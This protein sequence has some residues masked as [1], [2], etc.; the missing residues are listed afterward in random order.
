MKLQKIFGVIVLSVLTAIIGSVTPAS[1]IP[2]FA[3]KYNVTCTTCHSDFPK[4]NDFGVRF[5]QEG[6]QLPEKDTKS[7]TQVSIPISMRAN[8]GYNSTKV[9]EDKYGDSWRNSDFD[10]DSL[11]ILSGGTLAD[12]IGF[13]FAYRPELN[14]SYATTQEA[15]LDLANIVFMNARYPWLNIRAGRFEPAYL[16]FSERR[17]LSISPYLIYVLPLPGYNGGNDYVRGFS[18]AD[19]QDGIELTG[20]FA[21]GTEYAAGWVDAKHPDTDE[22]PPSDFYLRFARHSNTGESRPYDWRLGATAL[23]GR[24][25]SGRDYYSGTRSSFNRV[26]CDATLKY[27]NWDMLLQYIHGHDDSALWYDQDGNVDLSGGFA[28]VDYSKSSKLVGFA[29]YDWAKVPLMADWD[30]SRLTLGGRYYIQ[31][32]IALHLEYSRMRMCDTSYG[33]YSYFYNTSSSSANF[34]GLRLDF[35]F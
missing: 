14:D 32:N 3:H 19:S 33:E 26:G 10:I 25:A 16:A 18:M 28:E 27:G 12:N 34:Y 4:L 6:Y 17:R 24:V 23:F 21:N 29:R 13:V 20:S 7:D 31:D 5:R 15:S 11:E 1:A 2:A 35:A 8:F 22:N 30:M 9:R